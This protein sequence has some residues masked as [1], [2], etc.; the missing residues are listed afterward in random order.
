MIK[1]KKSVN[2]FEKYFLLSGKRIL[3]VMIAWFIIVILHNLVYGLFQKYFD[4]RGGDEPFFFIL[5][6]IV[7][8]IYFIIAVVYSLV[9]K[10]KN[11][12]YPKKE[13]YIKLMISFVGGLLITFI[14]FVVDF[15]NLQGV[16][17]SVI[18]FTFL[19]FGVISLFQA[20]K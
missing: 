4:A 19:M 13:F 3:I 20:K 10:I 15:L 12:K 9:W 6:I 7:I 5:A 14:L 2:K 8:P 17:M 1:Q 16:W 18:V 11:K